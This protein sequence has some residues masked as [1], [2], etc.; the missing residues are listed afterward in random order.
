MRIVVPSHAKHTAC[1]PERSE[2]PYEPIEA[3][4]QSARFYALHAS[5]AFPSTASKTCWRCTV[6]HGGFASIQDDKPFTRP[7]IWSHPLGIRRRL[8]WQPGG[9][10]FFCWPASTKLACQLCAGYFFIYCCSSFFLFL[11][12]L[13]LC[14][15]IFQ[16]DRAVEYWCSGLGIKVGAEVAQSLELVAAAGRGVRERRL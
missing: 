1:H 11:L 2:G 13:D 4:I 15:G 12:S 8:S 3:A 6:L 5:W 7:S 9:T 10:Q 16:R 14:P